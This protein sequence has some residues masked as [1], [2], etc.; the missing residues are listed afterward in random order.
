MRNIPAVLV[1]LCCIAAARGAT[2]YVATT[3]NDSNPGSSGSPWLTLQHA[4]ATAAN[5]DTVNV[6]A[7]TYVENDATRHSFN[8]AKGIT[9]VA[10]PTVTVKGTSPA[11][12]AVY[13]SGAGAAS[14]SGFTFD[15]TVAS[16]QVIQIAAA[17]T[18]KTFINC[19]NVSGAQYVVYAGAND[20][21]ILFNG[22][23]FTGGNNDAVFQSA[24]GFAGLTITNCISSQTKSGSFYNNDNISYSETVTI[25][26]CTITGGSSANGNHLIEIYC[27]GSGV[28][29]ISGCT[30]TSG[31]MAFRLGLAPG[32]I[33]ISNCTVQANN[34]MMNCT[35]SPVTVN[36]WSN[37]VTI[38]SGALSPVDAVLL[39][40]AS[41]GTILLNGNNISSTVQ[42]SGPCISVAGTFNATVVSNTIN[43]TTG[44]Q[45][46]LSI[47]TAGAPASAPVVAWNMFQSTATNSYVVNIG[48]DTDSSG[49]GRLNGAVITN[50]TVLGPYYYN[51]ALATGVTTHGILYGWNYNG[52]IRN[53]VV[54]GVGYGCVVKGNG[55]VWTSGG[56][57]YNLFINNKGEAGLRVKGESGLNIYNNTFYIDSTTGYS[58]ANYQGCISVGQNDGGQQSTNVTVKNNILY[59]VG[60]PASDAVLDCNTNYGFASDYNLFFRTTGTNMVTDSVDSGGHTWTFSAWKAAGYDAHSVSADALF[61]G[62]LTNLALQSSSPAINAGANVGLTNDIAGAPIVGLPDLGAY[63]FQGG[64]KM[65]P[66]AGRV[67]LSH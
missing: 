5:G 29:L 49:N 44:T 34:Y 13:I 48:N 30:I 23:S 28:F 21:A 18:N 16:K 2:Y 53:N 10:T 4:E 51:P 26:N 27:T 43:L 56:V 31:E 41:T 55:T 64:A 8:S 47:A 39:S 32:T 1:L 14:Y 24:G 11:T 40:S 50:N 15:G 35:A 19:T 54:H 6:A 3:G 20:A 33:T 37:V 12:E 46:L 62:V 42:L 7:G 25:I 22:C 57:F 36:L 17:A 38:V 63:E 61:S 58:G 66:I 65:L 60:N 9:W 67:I 45:P 59:H 52:V